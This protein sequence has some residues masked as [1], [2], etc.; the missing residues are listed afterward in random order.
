[1]QQ[2]DQQQQQQQKLNIKLSDWLCV[3]GS[4]LHGYH[5]RPQG[6]GWSIHVHVSVRAAVHRGNLQGGDNY[7]GGE[8]AE[9]RDRP[10]GGVQRCEGVAN[11]QPA[12]Q[13]EEQIPPCWPSRCNAGKYGP[14]NV[15]N[16]LLRILM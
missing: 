12:R 2:P 3:S 4:G 15:N 13:H 10:S 6:A 14:Q 11:G 1:M 7:H 5:W 8:E 9:A 16:E